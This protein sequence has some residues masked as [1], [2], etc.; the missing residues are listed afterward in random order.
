MKCFIKNIQIK[1]DLCFIANWYCIV[2]SG[3]II[4]KHGDAYI[5]VFLLGTYHLLPWIWL[6]TPLPWSSWNKKLRPRQICRYYADD[7]YKCIFFNKNI[8][9]RLMCAPK[10]PINNIP[11][12]V[13]I[14]A[15]CRLGDKPL[16][17]RMMVN[18][19]RHI[20]LRHSALMINTVA[21]CIVS[22]T[23]KSLCILI[24]LWSN[25]T[26]DKS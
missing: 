23:D 13:R 10:G 2:F 19:W 5:M 16:Y 18:Y 3:I 9:F 11:A 1:F 7:T 21:R 4:V 24:L 15:W 14:M 25:L 22:A 6:S 26:M 8:L 20:Y 12:L 17:E